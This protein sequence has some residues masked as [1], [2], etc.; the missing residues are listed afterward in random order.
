MIAELVNIEEEVNPKEFTYEM[1]KKLK[2][3]LEGLL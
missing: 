2:F 3:Y 1:T